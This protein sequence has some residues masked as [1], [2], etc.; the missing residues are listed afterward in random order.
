MATTASAIYTIPDYQCIGDSLGTI[1]NNFSNLNT[2]IVSLSSQYINTTPGLADAWVVFDGTTGATSTIK[3]QYNV[4]SVTRNSV[5]N[6]T[7]TFTTPMRNSNYAVTGL[8]SAGAAGLNM[9]I[10]SASGPGGTPTNLTTTQV[11]IVFGN[12]TNTYDTKYASVII[13]SL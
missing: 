12:G 8:N 6:Y 3:S 5:G 2:N 7:I 10:Y 4:S 9:A 13:F 1:N 11:Q